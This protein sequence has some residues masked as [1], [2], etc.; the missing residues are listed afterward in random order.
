MACVFVDSCDS[1]ESFCHHL[2]KK[3]LMEERSWKLFCVLP[4]LLLY[5]PE[6]KPRVTKEDMCRLFDL[7]GS[8]TPFWLKPFGSRSRF[9]LLTRRDQVPC[10]SLCPVRRRFMPRRGWYSSDV[11]S[12][13]VQVLRVRRNGLQRKTLTVFT[14]PGGGVSRNRTRFILC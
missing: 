11:A 3:K 8:G 4:F 12:G 1:C 5:R 10:F 2:K 9:L 13:C 7:F 14:S 6:D